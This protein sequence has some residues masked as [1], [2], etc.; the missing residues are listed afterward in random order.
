M[1][2]EI[3]IEMNL[4]AC[5]VLKEEFPMSIPYVKQIPNTERYSFKAKVQSFQAPGR[6]VLGLPKDVK[7]AGSK[8]FTRYINKIV[9]KN[10]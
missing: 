8:E 2:K 1:N 3:E 9:K 7:V 4:R 5:L 10:L 6:F